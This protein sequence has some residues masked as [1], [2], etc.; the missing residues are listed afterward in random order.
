M[1]ALCE[2]GVSGGTPPAVLYKELGMPDQTFSNTLSLLARKKKLDRDEVA[3][4]LELRREK[5]SRF[6]NTVTLKTLGESAYLS[7]GNGRVRGLDEDIKARDYHKDDLSTQGIFPGHPYTVCVEE[8]LHRGWG[9]LRSG[10]WVIV[11]VRF[12]RD[13]PRSSYESFHSLGLFEADASSLIETFHPLTVL[14]FLEKI[15][16]GWSSKR[17]QQLEELSDV[18]AEMKHETELYQTIR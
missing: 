3:A 13:H 12:E 7:S 10:A 4:L 5:I 9:I 8:R 6:L 16:E 14:R 17:R 2:C 11:D 1:H 15:V 18:L